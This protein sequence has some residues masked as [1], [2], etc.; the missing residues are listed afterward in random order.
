MIMIFQ[1]WSL[2]GQSSNDCPY[3]FKPFSFCASIKVLM[4]YSTLSFIFVIFF[5]VI[6]IFSY[7]FIDKKIY[8]TFLEKKTAIINNY[9]FFT[10]NAGFQLSFPSTISPLYPPIPQ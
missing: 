9:I 2:Y 8:Y 1:S 4:L 3:F 7:N 6:F 10:F 5:V